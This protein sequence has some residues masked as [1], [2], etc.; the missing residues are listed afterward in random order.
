ME[1][2][3]ADNHSS[4]KQ[5]LMEF[6]K[7]KAFTHP[8]PIDG[9]E[10]MGNPASI[11]FCKNNFPSKQQMAAVALEQKA[12]MT[13]FVCH[14][15]DNTFR[16][17]YFAP[18]GDEFSLCGH[19]TII[20]SHF[21]HDK[22]GFEEVIFWKDGLADS[23]NT[24]N[25]KIDGN[26]EF[27]QITMPGHVPLDIDT[28]KGIDYL[29]LLGIQEK[30]VQGF[31]ECKV[32]DDLIV[33]LNNST[34]LRNAAPNFSALADKLAANKV[35]GLFITALS[36]IDNIDYE[37]RI[38]APHFDIDEDI[39]C[40]SANCSL[41]PLWSKRTLAPANKEFRILCPYNQTSGKIGGLEI[42][43]YNK[44]ALTINIGGIISE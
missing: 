24:I 9:K 34:A 32:L 1:L 17:D 22:Y 2:T 10:V 12:P 6:F 41:L 19:A 39:S 20:A 13:A 21:I 36:A 4:P 7:G 23:L 27:T 29:P 38:F 31:Y 26:K 16:I 3:Q 15:Y 18:S 43:H 28:T 8:E 14:Q 42:G 11:V 5:M 40:G 44:E 33:V 25:I 37:V 30:D 35:R